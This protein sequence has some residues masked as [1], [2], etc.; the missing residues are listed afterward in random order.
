M[1]FVSPFGSTPFVGNVNPSSTALPQNQKQ[2]QNPV[3][4]KAPVEATPSNPFQQTESGPAEL[5]SLINTNLYAKTTS[6]SS[7]N[8]PNQKVGETNGPGGSSTVSAVSTPQGVLTT[9]VNDKTGQVFQS[10]NGGATNYV[11]NINT[12]SFS[13]QNGSSQVSATSTP[14]GTEITTTPKTS[15]SFNNG[16]SF[17]GGITTSTPFTQVKSINTNNGDITLSN[18][19]VLTQGSNAYTNFI[20][21]NQNAI[22]NYESDLSYN[23]KNKISQLLNGYALQG[24]TANGGTGPLY[25][26]FGNNAQVVF[27]DPH[28]SAYTVSYTLPN[29]QV[30]EYSG[31]VYGVGAGTQMAKD[32]AVQN[33]YDALQSSYSS[34]SAL[35]SGATVQVSESPQGLQTNIRLSSINGVSA[36][37]NSQYQTVQISPGIT[38][39]L[40]TTV[41]NNGITTNGSW[42]QGS[43]GGFSF[44]PT[45]Q[46]F[47]ASNSDTL[48]L[49][50]SN[51]QDLTLLNDLIGTSLTYSQL[52]AL[53]SS[54]TPITL[55]LTQSPNGGSSIGITTGAMSGATSITFPKESTIN[56]QSQNF[57]AN[58]FNSIYPAGQDAITQ[59]VLSTG[60]PAYDPNTGKLALP[61]G[62]SLDSNNNLIINN[63]QPTLQ[64]S[65]QFANALSGYLA[66]NQQTPQAM[67]QSTQQTSQLVLP[68]EPNWLTQLN[69][70]GNADASIYAANLAALGGGTLNYFTPQTTN[71]YNQLGI[72]VSPATT[73]TST[74]IKFPE[75]LNIKPSNVP[76]LNSINSINTNNANQVIYKGNN[77]PIKNSI[78]NVLQ[79]N[80]G[81]NQLPNAYSYAPIT[82]QVYISPITGKPYNPYYNNPYPILQ[83]SLTNYTQLTPS[84][85]ISGLENYLTPQSIQ[86]NLI[87]PSVPYSNYYNSVQLPSTSNQ[88]YSGLNSLFQNSIIPSQNNILKLISTKGAESLMPYLQSQVSQ[89]SKEIVK[90]PLIRS[91]YQSNTNNVPSSSNQYPSFL[92]NTFS[93]A[94]SDVGGILNNIITP[95][96]FTLGSQPLQKGSFPSNYPYTQSGINNIRLYYPNYAN[97]LQNQLN[98]LNLLSQH[99]Y[100]ETISNI[101]YQ[102][103]GGGSPTGNNL[104]NTAVSPQ[105][106]LKIAGLSGLGLLTALAPEFFVPEDALIGAG[107]GA[108][109]NPA[110]GEVFSGGNM[111]PQQL[112]QSGLLGAAF[113]GVTGGFLPSITSDVIEPAIGKSLAAR[114]ASG[115][116]TNLGLS[117]AY[118]LATT[119]QLS[120]LNNDIISAGIGGA[121]PSTEDLFKEL[122]YQLSPGYLRSSDILGS[123]DIYGQRPTIYE[124]NYPVRTT[125]TGVSNQ[126]GLSSPL[127]YL[128]QYNLQ[129]DVNGFPLSS[130][131]QTPYSVTFP[132]GSTVKLD[133]P[134]GTEGR[135]LTPRIITNTGV[136]GDSTDYI[137]LYKNLQN[138][139]KQLQLQSIGEPNYLD[140]LPLVNS[141]RG[142][143]KFEEIPV[144]TRTGDISNVFT[145]GTE[146]PRPILKTVPDYKAMLIKILKNAM[147]GNPFGYIEDE[148]PTKE[149]PIGTYQ[150][151]YNSPEG[152][153][154]RMISGNSP[155]AG[156]LLQ[157][158]DNTQLSPGYGTLPESPL[159]YKQYALYNTLYNKLRRLIGL[160]QVPVKIGEGTSLL[161]GENT[162]LGNEN[163]M[164]FQRGVT[165]VAGQPNIEYRQNIELPSKQTIP[166]QLIKNSIPGTTGF[167]GE[168]FTPYTDVGIPITKFVGSSLDNPYV[169]FIAKGMQG[170]LAGNPYISNIGLDNL[171][172]FFDVQGKGIK[173]SSPSTSTSLGEQ[174]TGN[175]LP[176]Q[177]LGIPK[178]ESFTP[179][180]YVQN[181]IKNGLSL[182]F[183]EPKSEYSPTSNNYQNQG[184]VVPGSPSNFENPYSTVTSESINNIKNELGLASLNDNGE[185]TTLLPN[186]QNIFLNQ[187]IRKGL[188][189]LPG[190]PE[191]ILKL[192]TPTQNV[193]EPFQT[194]INPSFSSS[195]KYT[196]TPKIN[197]VLQPSTTLSIPSSS[198]SLISSPIPTTTIIKDVSTA[199]SNVLKTNTSLD[200]SEINNIATN[201][202][203]NIEPQIANAINQSMNQNNSL[204]MNVNISQNIANAINQNLGFELSQNFNQELSQQLAQQLSQQLALI[205]TLQLNE[206]LPYISL[207]FLNDS[208]FPI[209]KD[210]KLNNSPAIYYTIYSP[211]L[212]PLILPNTEKL[213]ETTY[214]PLTE[215]AL[216]RPEKVPQGQSLSWTP[217]Q[218]AQQNIMA[219]AGNQVKTQLGIPT[220]TT[221]IPNTFGGSAPATLLNQQVVDPSSMEIIPTISQNFANGPNIVPLPP[222]TYSGLNTQVSASE[223]LNTTPSF[224]TQPYLTQL[225]QAQTFLDK[226]PNLVNNSS[227]QLNSTPFQPQ[228]AFTQ[229]G[230][231][232]VGGRLLL[233]TGTQLISVLGA[234]KTLEL[235]NQVDPK[236]FSAYNILYGNKNQL[237][238]E[239]TNL[240]YVDT[241]LLMNSLTPEQRAQIYMAINGAT[242]PGEALSM[243]EGL[244]LGLI[245][246]TQ[247]A[248][249]GTQTKKKKVELPTQTE[250]TP[251]QLIRL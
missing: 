145:V 168:V 178:I 116:L 149:V 117:N 14:Q 248:L 127:D 231:G 247:Q 77:T 191:E 249:Q 227:P 188:L 51:P 61:T 72:A 36:P 2:T 42:T 238:N 212:L 100:P 199:I 120:S 234:T 240:S 194:L 138:A 66:A 163:I 67:Q 87:V 241:L 112:V 70:S 142:N 71:Y 27:P 18:G 31:N 141:L 185:T 169:K 200:L 128:N 175:P 147:T 19:T 102:F 26:T 179:S 182:I 239:L 56:G 104:I 43:N 95:S 137:Q 123:Q 37:Q 119:G 251:R 159:E 165:P 167:S 108:V 90:S 156:N 97:I 150:A 236:I 30:F 88:S 121:F 48:I 146:T 23:Q 50:P 133:F 220:T 205:L 148:I 152:E 64:Q 52:Q 195:N 111:T 214:S 233:P 213:A 15:A 68:A 222:A 126:Y 53:Q 82:N 105:E 1:A 243:A 206:S 94:V 129:K 170:P 69:N 139:A 155:G 226:N 86:N 16:G 164:Q 173:V 44:T 216:F 107:I 204:G 183:D 181:N 7:Q 190:V 215:A 203:Y 11:G 187:A 58:N 218:E 219:A 35:P 180:Q 160:S 244:P 60:I 109:A 63:Q 153:P 101:G 210:N 84:Q 57:F 132:D 8:T 250:T 134:T 208:Y 246:P 176:L 217:T 207:P 83:P 154:M 17:T 211:S 3:A 34:F 171:P 5:T 189:T 85:T 25:S 192:P 186:T 91:Q 131:S 125:E 103:L 140:K 22:N 106:F 232:T 166:L 41:N 221:N 161:S 73:G 135:V 224:F 9:T 223:P 184:Y 242:T 136:T 197:T 47:T 235:L 143:V 92:T 78:S 96:N 12:G 198:L 80:L 24:Y 225:G 209:K 174:I 74:T 32:Q 124:Y 172:D 20:L 158:S 151:F 33:A 75:I 157:T 98:Q 59:Q 49:N 65:E 230:N 245:P 118:N 229:S 228:I 79:G 193:N 237:F 76:Y 55:T 81:F 177:N 10:L 114:A 202:A 93:N 99:G 144:S 122:K 162:Q 40:P 28:G 110:I 113:G 201:L 115:A 46:V 6:Q 29:G 130:P 13:F 89:P 62:W 196:N 45:S 21:N 38:E 39:Q 4:T 54:N